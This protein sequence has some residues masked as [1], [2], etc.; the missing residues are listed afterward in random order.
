[1]TDSASN[2]DVTRLLIEWKNGNAD[3]YR[4]LIPLVYDQLKKMAKGIVRR[5]AHGSSSSQS[6]HSTTLVHE[7]YLRL[8]DESRVDWQCRAHFFAIAANEARRIVIDEYRRK[9]ADKRGGVQARVPLSD[10]QLE[11]GGPNVDLIALDQALTKLETLD[12]RQAKIVELHYF[13]GLTNSETAAVLGISTPTVERELNHARR[14][15]RRQLEGA[16]KNCDGI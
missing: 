16:K 7:V 4:E 9:T 11:V 12:E 10:I 15:L 3:A 13:G 14:W 2:H 8:I 1:M 5:Q 6:L